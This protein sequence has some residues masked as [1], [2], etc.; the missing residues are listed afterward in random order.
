MNIFIKQPQDA[1]QGIEIPNDAEDVVI[2][3]IPSASQKILISCGYE[4]NGLKFE[5]TIHG[6][7]QKLEILK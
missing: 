7:K 2:T 3:L 5:A 4:K 1:I 6:T